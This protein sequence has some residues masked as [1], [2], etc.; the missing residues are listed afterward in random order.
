MADASSTQAGTDPDRAG[1]SIAWQA[2]RDLVILAAGV[3]ADTVIDRAGTIGRHVL[4]GLLPARRLRVSPRVVK[5]AVSKNQTRGSR[6][7]RTSYKA[8]TSINILASPSPRRPAPDP[9]LHGLDPSPA[10]GSSRAVLAGGGQRRPR[11][12]P[13]G[14]CRRGGEGA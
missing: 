4:A 14:E 6:I 9:E 8:T 2:A 11:G 13:H 10:R 7:D 1:F 12:S 5:R 3:I